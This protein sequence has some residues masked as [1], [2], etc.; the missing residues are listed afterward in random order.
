MSDVSVI[1]PCYNR[2]PLIADTLRSVLGQTHIPAEVIVVDD[3]S[4]DNTAEVVA[5]FP[6]VR[7]ERIAN[8]GVC[9]ARNVGVGLAR[10]SWLAFCDSDDLWEPDRLE[11][12]FRLL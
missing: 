12:Q 6:T 1:I 3:G 11:T 7:Y 9:R 8:S 2:G 5:G 4:T 10:F